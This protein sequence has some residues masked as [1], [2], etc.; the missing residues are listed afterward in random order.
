MN[1]SVIIGKED[2]TIIY[3]DGSIE[4]ISIEEFEK[5]LETNLIKVPLLMQVIKDENLY[6]LSASKYSDKFNHIT[7]DI[8]LL[9]K[10]EI[11]HFESTHKIKTKYFKKSQYSIIK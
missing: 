3:D 10:N 11:E 9:L 5:R 6:Q 2:C 1:S 8:E 4:K 7:E